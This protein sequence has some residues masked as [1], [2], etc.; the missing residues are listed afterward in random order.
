MS[1]ASSARVQKE[2]GRF[3]SIALREPVMITNHGREDLVLLSAEEY[4]RLKRRDREALPA[5]ALSAEQVEALASVSIPA[6]AAALD[7]EVQD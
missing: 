2:F 4:R 5:A 7:D 6:E 1:V 3:R